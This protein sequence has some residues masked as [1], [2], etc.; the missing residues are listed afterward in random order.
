MKERGGVVWEILWKEI[1]TSTQAPLNAGL[2]G[3]WH[4]WVSILSA[5]ALAAHATKLAQRMQAVNRLRWLNPSWE[6]SRRGKADKQCIHSDHGTTSTEVMKEG[7]NLTAYCE[8]NPIW[9]QWVWSSSCCS[10][11]ANQTSC[12]HLSHGETPWSRASPMSLVLGSNRW[13]YQ[14]QCGLWTV[15]QVSSGA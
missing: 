6:Q 10:H 4:H 15:L 3:E 13:T 11:R 5:D 9:R 14:R 1:Y 2:A 7:L 12:V 8:N